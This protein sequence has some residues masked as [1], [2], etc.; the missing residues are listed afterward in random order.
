[1]AMKT[2]DDTKTATTT[3]VKVFGV[4]AWRLISKESSNQQNWTKSTKAMQIDGVGCLVQVTSQYLNQDGSYAL[5]EA[6]TFVPGVQVIEDEHG[7]RALV[8]IQHL[9]CQMQTT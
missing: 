7:G 9:T 1:M 8:K 3:D 2:L 4:D 5:S 6:L